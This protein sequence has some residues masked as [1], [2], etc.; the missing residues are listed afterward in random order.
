MTFSNRPKN[1]RC[2]R[3]ENV[4]VK[5]VHFCYVTFSQMSVKRHQKAPNGFKWPAHTAQHK[6][7]RK[8]RG[9][10]VRRSGD[11]IARGY[12]LPGERRSGTRSWEEAYS[13]GSWVNHDDVT[14]L[15][16]IASSQ[17]RSNAKRRS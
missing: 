8:I 10:C 4:P 5:H 17:Q 3:W 7:E 2:H 1:E 15:G 6:K 11:P 12:H 16:G 9:L 14:I 13:S